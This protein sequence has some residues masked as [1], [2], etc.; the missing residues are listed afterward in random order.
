M[1]GKVIKLAFNSVRF[2][3]QVKV[4]GTQVG[5]NSDGYLPFEFTIN[6]NLKASDNTTTVHVEADATAPSGQKM[7]FAYNRGIWQDVYLKAYPL[8][9][10]ENTFFVRTSFRNKRITT[11]IPVKN[12]DTKARTIYVKNFVVDAAGAIVLTFESPAQT[13]AAGKL[14]TVNISSAWTN[15]RCW[16]PE[17]P[18][19]YTIHTVIYDSDQTTV[20]DWQKTKFGFKELWAV[21]TQFYLNGKKAFLRGDSFH[22]HGEYQQTRQYFVALFSSMKEWG[23]NY[24]RP[25]TL[26]YDPIMYDVADSIGMMIIAET[27]IY[28]SDGDDEGFYP[29][30]CRR[31]VERDRNRPSIAL[32]SS[33]NEVGHM[34]T[35]HLVNLAYVQERDSTRIAYAEENKKTSPQV[36]SWH[37]FDQLHEG[38][39]TVALPSLTTINNT[40][41]HIMGEY[42][43]PQITAFG[44][45]GTSACGYEITSQD[46]GAGYFSHGET[47]LGQ[48][49]A[50]QEKRI[51]GGYCSWCIHWGALR[52]QPFFN[53]DSAELKWPDLTAPGAKPFRIRAHQFSINWA[54]PDLPKYVPLPWFYLY[55]PLY[56]AIRFTDLMPDWKTGFPPINNRNFYAGATIS[57]PCNLWYESF[58]DANHMKTE[59][60]KAD[61]SVLS[62]TDNTGTPW[63]NIQAGTTYN[64]LT[65]TW[66]APNVTEQTPVSINRTFYS[67]TTK[68]ATVAF[69]GNIFPRFKAAHLPG[70]SGKKVGLFDPAGTTKAIFDNIGLTYTAVSALSGVTNAAYDVLVIGASNP[71]TGLPASFAQNGG[72]VLC[73]SQ[74]VKPSLPITLPAIV[75]GGTKDVQFLL[76]G[77]KHK[78]FE[79]LDQRDMTFWANSVNTAQNV[80]E[81]P[82]AN[83]NIRVLCASNNNGDN[84]PIIEVPSGKGTYILSQMEIVPQFANEPV[85]GKLLVN[86]LNYLG[87]YSAPKLSKTGLIADAGAIKTYYDG[88]QL[89]YDALTASALPADLSSYVTI[90]IDG[91]SSSIATSLSNAAVV[92]KLNA[93]VSAGGQVV[94]NQINSNTIAAYNQIMSQFPLTLNTVAPFKSSTNINTTSSSDISRSVKC[95]VSW[96]KKSSPAEIVRY[97]YL[98]MP[99][100]FE[101]N[102]DPLLMGISNKDLDWTARQADAGVKVTGKKYP[103]VNALIA[104]YRI[105]WAWMAPNVILDKYT[106]PL[107]RPKYQNDWFVKRNPTLLKLKQGSGFWLVNQL[108]LQNDAVKGRRIGNLLLTGLGASVGSDIYVPGSFSVAVQ[109][110]DRA[111][112]VSALASLINVWSNPVTKTV[113]IVY[114]LPE[115][116]QMT[117]NVAVSIFNI[118]G[119]QVATVTKSSG[120]RAGRNEIVINKGMLSRG[121]YVMK[122]SVMQKNGKRQN[123]S[124]QLTICN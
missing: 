79:G 65:V 98:N 37:Y 67:G 50:L 124:R 111:G 55:V 45:K 122:L 53:N 72:R 66:T 100:P 7:N 51:Y 41:V 28:G 123:L 80:Y 2:V 6:S 88:L 93:Y 19:L 25:H 21:G 69:E 112:N 49:W 10:V 54:D 3:C 118:S 113:K 68:Q 82:T 17:D 23:C 108:L 30:H 104:P 16:I 48:T 27:A 13:L 101:M 26:P 52:H 4:N 83:E 106:S 46:Y 115:N 62:S 22:F 85:A 47:T 20:V 18:Y 40:Q 87:T 24:F 105:D 73:L 96:L 58:Q 42:T 76:N 77:A 117:D 120:L 38:L 71:T 95:A 36:A 116:G 15:P 8:V 99:S 75:A 114:T 61:G 107:L 31:F 1:N 74:T 14:D 64:G 78:I 94:V 84:A 97:G 89:R 32:W 39:Y 119:R 63:N 35:D 60:V 5:I 102:P 91:S 59:I 56:Q 43:Q 110:G 44:E 90:I 29:D 109:P 92:T 57:R 103:E 9:S 12:N 121:V 34:G 33:S 70:I 11:N 86:M 81:R